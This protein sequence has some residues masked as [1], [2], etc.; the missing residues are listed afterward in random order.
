MVQFVG[1]PVTKTLGMIGKKWSI[2]IIND[3]FFGK[4]RF[5]QF[6]QAHPN[7]SPKVLSTRL[8]EMEKNGLI[9]KNVVE[10]TPIKV[11]YQLTEKGLSLRYLMFQFAMFSIINNPEELI[12]NPDAALEEI[13]NDTSAKYAFSKY[14]SSVLLEL[15]TA[16]QIQSFT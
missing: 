6:L 3:L 10:L 12:D 15:H 2:N 11:E 1:C 4:T 5:S 9:S 13:I 8:K 14:E 16:P 7:L